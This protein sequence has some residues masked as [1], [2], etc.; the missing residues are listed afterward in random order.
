[1]GKV[2]KELAVWRPREARLRRDPSGLTE[3]HGWVH[4][5]N[6]AARGTFG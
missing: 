6:E 4:S 2:G 3:S 5:L 1:M